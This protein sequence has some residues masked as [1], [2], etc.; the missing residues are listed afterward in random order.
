ME[1]VVEI[2]VHWIRASRCHTSSCCVEVGVWRTSSASGNNGQCV[3]VSG[4]SDG[5][6]LVRDSKDSDGPVLRFTPDEWRAFLVGARL[7]EFD[8]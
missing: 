4:V 6:V 8:V 2:Y 5:D 7:G 1:V 3:E